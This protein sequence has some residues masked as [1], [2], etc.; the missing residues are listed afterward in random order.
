MCVSEWHESQISI[1]SLRVEGD[2]KLHT[3][4]D[5]DLVISIHSLRVEG[6]VVV[7]VTVVPNQSISIHSLRVEGD[8]KII[9]TNKLKYILYVL[10]CITAI[11][12]MCSDLAQEA[13]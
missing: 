12:I 11:L 1:H 6:D 5:A 3:A 7:Y 2:F 9:Q 13:L 4:Y 10:F 8:S